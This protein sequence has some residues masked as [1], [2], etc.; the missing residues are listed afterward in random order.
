[1]PTTRRI[2]QLALEQA[3]LD[4]AAALVAR[5]SD[6]RGDR[7]LAEALER[8]GELRRIVDAIGADLA[9][10]VVSRSESPED[11]LARRL[12][13]GSA[14]DSI[15]RLA[16][17]ESGEALDWCA[18]AAFTRPRSSL[19]GEPLPPRHSG[20]AAALNAAT[21]SPRA[22]RTIGQT[23]DKLARKLPDEG[24]RQAEQVLTDF[25]PGLAARELTR[26]CTQ[27]IDRFDPDGVAPREE[28]LVAGRGLQIIKLRDGSTKWVL[29]LDP[30]SEGF[31]R[32]ALDARTAPRRRPTFEDPEAL[33]DPALADDRTLAQRRLDTVV[34]WARE[35]VAHDHGQV[36]GTAVTMVI[37]MPL[38]PGLHRRRR[39]ADQRRNRPPARRRSRNH[40]RRPRHQERTPRLGL[41]RPPL[42]A[43]PAPGHGPA[44]RRMHL[45]RPSTGLVR[46]RTPQTLVLH[47]RNQPRKRRPHVPE[48]PCEV[49]SRRLATRMARRRALAHPARLHRPGSNSAAGTTA[50][51][52]RHRLTAL[53]CRGATIPGLA[54]SPGDF[55]Q[56]RRA[57]AAVE[58]RDHD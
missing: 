10:D 47:K 42:L 33:E 55:R 29:T 57:A 24:V 3:L 6:V 13:D 58:S 1:V 12:G 41:V 48:R 38:R 14:R 30:L 46:G 2:L 18:A 28:E 11:S 40:P 37:T 17:I 7:S 31:L 21:L 27:A 22:V 8:V 26:L 32:T 51:S 43:S 44:R 45:V 4:T 35:S 34:A 20:L 36:A 54:A 15:A 9:G 53:A 52:A 19:T 50:A 16:G 39:P 23:L 5:L 49:R 25:A 56:S